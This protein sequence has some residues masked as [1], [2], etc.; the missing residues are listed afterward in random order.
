MNEDSEVIVPFATYYLREA[1]GFDDVL[2]ETLD[3][4][5]V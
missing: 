1:H 3:G 2:T 5:V 4:G